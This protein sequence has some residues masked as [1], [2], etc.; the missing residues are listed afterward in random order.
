MDGWMTDKWMDGQTDG[1]SARRI[2][3]WN[4][5][6]LLSAML[7]LVMMKKLALSSVETSIHIN[8]F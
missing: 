2:W 5:P 6:R 1:Q 3:L 7:R 4:S 8:V